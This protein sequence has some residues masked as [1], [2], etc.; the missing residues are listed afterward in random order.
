M[1]DCVY[2]LESPQ[3]GDSNENTTYL[4]VIEKQRDTYYASWPGAIINPHWLE[5]PLSQTNF[6]GPIGV[7]AIEVRLH[8]QICPSVGIQILKHSIGMGN[9]AGDIGIIWHLFRE[10]FSI[11]A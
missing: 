9:R 3:W 4:P 11:K 5:L 1:V 2:S 7:Q 6:H 10:D 8:S